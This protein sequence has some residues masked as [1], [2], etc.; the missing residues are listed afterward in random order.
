MLKNFGKSNGF[1]LIELIVAFSI[2]SILSSIGIASFIGY[3]SEQEFRGAYLEF[4]S[5]VSLAKSNALAQV[6]PDQCTDPVNPANSKVLVGYRTVIKDFKTY[7]IHA[8]CRISIN[9]PYDPSDIYNKQTFYLPR[10]VSFITPA[11]DIGI[12][13]PVLVSEVTPVTITLESKNGNQENVIIDKGGVITTEN[14]NQ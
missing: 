9:D 1:T 5:N 10:S 2:I 13:F 7:E 12:F 11:D 6:K 4:A 3:N 8:E 14:A